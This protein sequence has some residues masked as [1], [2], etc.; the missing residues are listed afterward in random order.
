M[1]KRE[2]TVG[3]ETYQIVLPAVRK[4]MFICTRLSVLLGGSAINLIVTQA[5]NNDGLERISSLLSKIDP[6]KLDG[7][8][9]EA[10]SICHLT[11][12]KQ[13][14]TDDNT[15]NQHFADKRSGV[16]Q[17]SLWVLWECVQD[18]FPQGG[19]FSQMLNDFRDMASQSLKDGKLTTG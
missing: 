16:Y 11:C 19:V 7:L 15:F 18:F 2:K 6:I 14:L 17:V 3:N 12:G 5:D 9:M 13:Q 1:H 4:A 8:M 10:I